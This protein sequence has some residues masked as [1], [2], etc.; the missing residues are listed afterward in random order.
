MDTVT[1]PDGPSL[2]RFVQGGMALVA[3]LWTMRRLRVPWCTA[4][5]GSS[6]SPGHPRRC[7]KEYR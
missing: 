2:P 6:S 3:P 4:A 5:P 1:L 7:G